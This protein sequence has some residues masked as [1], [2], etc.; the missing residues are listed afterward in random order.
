[1]Q[2]LRSHDLLENGKITDVDTTPN[3]LKAKIE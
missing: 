3:F 2:K 1:M